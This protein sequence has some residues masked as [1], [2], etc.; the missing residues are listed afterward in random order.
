MRYSSVVI[1]FL[2][3]L[4]AFANFPNPTPYFDDNRIAELLAGI[5]TTAYEI[6]EDFHTQAYLAMTYYPE[7]QGRKIKFKY[8]DQKTTMSCIPRWDFIFHKK[9]N[10]T[11][12]VRIDKALKGNE[13]VLLGDVPF[14][15]Q[16]GV[17]GHELGHIIDYESKGTFGVIGTGF[18]YLFSSYRRKLEN[19]VDEITIDRG[20][21]NQLADFADYV[22][23]E[24]Q[25]SPKYL[26]YKRKFYYQ[27]EEIH[28][29][30]TGAS[31]VP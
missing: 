18:R 25:A 27:P 8:K 21:G 29:L 10:R 12:V 3:S 26:K 19:H 6:P 2:L 17:I 1:F 4:S 20:L 28:S 15:A 7:L 16:V 11:Y 30:M 13:G 9:A 24:S 31:L 14:D 22:F 5:D 23:H